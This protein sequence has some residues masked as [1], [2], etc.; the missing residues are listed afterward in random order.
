MLVQR[1]QAIR[2]AKRKGG[3]WEKAEGLELITAG[4]GGSSVPAGM[5]GLV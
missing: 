3:S 5:L 2:Q 4:G 1:I